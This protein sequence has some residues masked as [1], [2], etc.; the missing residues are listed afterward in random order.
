MSFKF[1]PMLRV[2]AVGETL[3]FESHCDELVREDGRLRDFS[4]KLSGDGVELKTDMW[5]MKATPNFFMERY[6]N[7]EKQSPGGP[8]QSLANGTRYFIYFYLS[9]LTYYVFDTKSLCEFLEANAHTFEEKLVEN[10]KYSTLGYRVPRE[11]VAH[12][13]SPQ[14]MSI[15]KGEKPHG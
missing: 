12:L 10:Q 14:Y 6:S 1:S 11:A 9:N 3:F 2:G 8:F 15:A 7:V 13:T 5:D 4:Y